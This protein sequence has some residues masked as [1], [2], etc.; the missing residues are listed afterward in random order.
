[1]LTLY[2]IGGG[3][4]IAFTVSD[5]VW[6]TLTLDRGGPLTRLIAYSVSW[7]LSGR[8]RADSDRLPLL[9]QMRSQ[10]GV[11]VLL[12][13]LIG[14]SLGLWLG[15][16]A[17]LSGMPD[18]VVNAAT[19][20]PADASARFYYVGFNLVTLGIGDFIPRGEVARILTVVMASM[21]FFTTTLAITYIMPVVSAVIEQRKVALMIRR[22]GDSPSEI[23]AAGFDGQGF[24]PLMNEL[25]SIVPSLAVMDQQHAAYPVLHYFRAR[26][27]ASSFP[28]ALATLEEIRVLLGAG[29]DASVRPPKLA[30]RQLHRS[31]GAYLEAVSSVG[32]QA[33]EEPPPV[34]NRDL[35]R[36]A[37]I[38]VTSEEEFQH[39]LEAVADRR[40][41]H[42]GFVRAEG[43]S[44]DDVA[45]QG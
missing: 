3:L 16:F 31:V 40:C 22:L 38:P 12:A 33:A 34:P 11:L 29:V 8:G 36:E 42:L 10:L 15:W 21:G 24:D 25:R 39:G 9:Q 23:L 45:S 5:L 41:G 43:W 13:T 17:I 26:H 2:L 19:M 44:W 28:V 14:W 30:L 7:T 6:T 4:L 27:A 35:L 20:V 32:M 18:T 1:M 37:G